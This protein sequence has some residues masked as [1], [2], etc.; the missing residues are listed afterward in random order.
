MKTS[1]KT[2]KGGALKELRQFGEEFRDDFLDQGKKAVGGALSDFGSQLFGDYGSQQKPDNNPFGSMD[3]MNPF[4]R[5]PESFGRF[6]KQEKKEPKRA[7]KIEVVF[8]RS[9][10]MAERA[11][12][13]QIKELIKQVKNEVEAL[14]MQDAALVKDIAALSINEMPERAGIYHLRFLEFVIKLLQGIRKK[15]SEGRMWL[16][17]TF[18]KKNAKKHKGRSKSLGT[19]FSMSRELTQSTNP[20]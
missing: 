19:Q 7:R 13:N 18:D 11:V 3:R 1:Q 12:M 20:G 8:N 15:V 4:D 5:G 6:G 17:A 2:A 14:K 16:A 9:E 10:F